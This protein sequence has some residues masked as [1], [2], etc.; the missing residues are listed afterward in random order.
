LLTRP[1]DQILIERPTY[2]LLL[3]T[4]RYL[5]ADVHA[6]DREPVGFSVDPERVR[7]VVEGR[8]R[9][10]EPL[11]RLRLIVLTNLHNPSSA[12][13]EEATLRE[14]GD[15]AA[16]HGA[17]VLIDEIYLDALFDAAPR[18]AF[19]LGPTFITTNS[20]TKIYGLS[21]LRCGW[22]LAEPALA[23]RIRRLVDL[24]DVNPPHIAQRLSVVAL[25][26]L[27][28]GEASQLRRNA[29]ELLSRN[30]ELLNRFLS[31]RD[32]LEV[33]KH[34]HGTTSFPR[35][36]NGT[37]EDLLPLAERRGTFVT[38]G[39][40]FGSPER[41]RIGI[42][43]KSEIVE[44]GLARLGDALDALSRRAESEAVTR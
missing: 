28:R 34:R 10:V 30:V 4:A 19:F 32:D 35:L 39:S 37:A 25:R 26:E 5:L 29:R 23:R 22:I 21:G 1:G 9:G 6:F 41:V 12:L 31:S 27:A 13:L 3:D 18:S 44:Q 2:P 40:F 11:R 8:T 33:T 43:A 38:D 36:E 16:R 7:A 42:G 20:L 15:I 17:R 14:I 24:F